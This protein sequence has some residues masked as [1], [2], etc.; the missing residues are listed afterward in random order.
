MATA[1]GIRLAKKKI[2]EYKALHPKIEEVAELLGGKQGRK[3]AEDYHSSLVNALNRLENYTAEIKRLEREN[4]CLERE[5]KK[6]Y[7]TKHPEIAEEEAKKLENIINRNK[8]TI[9]SYESSIKEL[10]R[11]VED[12]TKKMNEVMRSVYDV[13]N[14]KSNKLVAYEGLTRRKEIDVNDILKSGEEYLKKRSEEIAEKM[15]GLALEIGRTEDKRKRKKL[16]AEYNQLMKESQELSYESMRFGAAERL[17]GHPQ[18]KRG[19][20]NKLRNLRK[21]LEVGYRGQKRKSS[22]E[23]APAGSAAHP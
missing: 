9:T 6:L 4:K 13:I 12:R 15:A 18:E 11:T 2:K 1:E 8:G 23:P 10:A 17:I 20:L 16:Q 19:I 22:S 5:I 21:M 7:K 14:G 3:L